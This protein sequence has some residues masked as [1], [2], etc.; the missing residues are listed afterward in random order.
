MNE[1]AP[2]H[3]NRALSFREGVNSACS[4][5]QQQFYVTST[6]APGTLMTDHEGVHCSHMLPLA[7]ASSGSQAIG[8]LPHETGHS[9]TPPSIDE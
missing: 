8:S 6:Y 5:R 7:H 1:L 9:Y 3:I 2:I 4:T